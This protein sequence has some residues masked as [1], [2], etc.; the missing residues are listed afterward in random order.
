MAARDSAAPTGSRG[1]DDLAGGRVLGDAVR[2][3][4]VLRMD[5]EEVGDDVGEGR[6]CRGELRRV[7]IEPAGLDQEPRVT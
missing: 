2:V 1:C 4:G 6:A 7:R 3:H 5:E